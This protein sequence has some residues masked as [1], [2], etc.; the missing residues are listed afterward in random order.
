MA[1]DLTLI[2]GNQK[3]SGWNSIR[4]TRGVE[5]CPS[6]FDI[7]MTERYPGELGALVILPGDECQVVLGRDLVLTGYIDRFNPSITA[8]QHSVRISGRSK[9]ADLVDCMAEWDGGQI[10][11]SAVLD[12]AIKLAEPYGILVSAEIGNVLTAPLPHSVLPPPSVLSMMKK[13]IPQ[14]NLMLGETPF[15]VIERICRYRALLVYDQPDGNLVIATVG[16]TQAASGFA[17]GINVQNASICYSMDGRYSEYFASSQ[18]VDVF[19]DI[20]NL[21]YIHST[22]YDPGVT[23]HRR[24]FIHCESGQSGLDILQP[25]ADWEASRR[26]GRSAQL[27]LT[28]DGWRDSADVLYEPNTLVHISL[29]GLNT[30]NK[31]WLISEVVYRLDE[32]GTT[33]DLIIMP[34]AAFAPEP[35]STQQVAGGSLPAELNR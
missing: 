11:N 15:Q 25:R 8:Q 35:I 3:V 26:F 23:R 30:D 27:S 7:E 17:E 12:I 32:N 33:C 21:G 18:S 20:G 24:H 19:D 14:F 2:I 16:T 5:R 9:C 31:L 22:A 6:D 4:V 29:P 10:T 13:P 34:P 28:T 1:D